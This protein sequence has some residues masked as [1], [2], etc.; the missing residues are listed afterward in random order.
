MRPLLSAAAIF[1][2]VVAARPSV[3]HAQPTDPQESAVAIELTDTAAKMMDEGNYE[4]A[5]AKLEEAAK[6]LPNAPGILALLA[7]CYENLHRYAS[8]WSTYRLAA[9]LLS[10][11]GDTRAASQMAN[12]TRLAARVSK[13]LVGV[14]KSVEDAKG[15]VILRD[16]KQIGR[17]QWNTLVAI[18]GGTHIV[19]VEVPGKLPTERT[20][21]VAE[22]NDTATV[23]LPEL[24]EL[25]DQV[26]PAIVEPP[27]KVPP[28]VE[29]KD[30]ATRTPA[31]WAWAVGGAGLAAIAVGAGFRID[32]FL[33]EED[34]ADACGPK[35]DA[36]PA[37]YDV[38]GT[39][40]QKERD[41]GV[42]V[43]MTVAGSLA[44]GV[45]VVGLV[46]HAVQSPPSKAPASNAATT[47]SLR[48]LA[49]WFDGRS[50]GLGALG[51]F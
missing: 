2:A 22:Q 38:E 8:A 39:N 47:V 44:V 32:G 11:R 45:G 26:T 12:V 15:T 50:A 37:A 27:P 21:F 10:A 25:A 6:L 35:R 13:I 17:A 40:A 29:P 42:F 23:I 4:A 48:G 41:Y 34:Q 31:I 1:A 7:Q 28:S 14:P 16:D 5:S 36:C 20:V 51:T 49:P 3:A 30:A 19:R 18:D 24:G 33:V 46:V 43:G 9:D